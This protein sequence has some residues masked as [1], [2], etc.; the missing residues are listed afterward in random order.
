MLLVL[1]RTGMRIGELLNCKTTDV[2]LADKK[3]LIYEGEKNRLG[4][5]VCLS[6]DACQALK[7][8]LYL[9]DA[10]KEYLFYSR[11]RPTLSYTAAR[12]I[13]CSCLQE[14]GLTDMHLDIKWKKLLIAD[15]LG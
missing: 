6:E 9:R 3:I 7:D 12:N 15:I 11:F 8:W 14:A 2:R 4:R 5:S 1:L 13:F 10:Q